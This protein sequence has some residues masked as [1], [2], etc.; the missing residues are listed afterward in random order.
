MKEKIS[1]SALLFFIA[2]QIC[3]SQ[4]YFIPQSLGV[5]V[6]SSY[7][8]INP[9]PTP[10]GKTVY[11]TR[12]D[13][14]ENSG[15]AKKSADILFTTLK[16]DGTWSSAQSVTALNKGKYNTALSFSDNGNQLLFYSD[17][18]FYLST[19]RADTWSTPEKL[20]FKA[21]KD[22]QLSNDGQ[23]LIFSKGGSIFISAKNDDGTW[24]KPATIKSIT[25]KN[26]EA[27]FLLADN[28]TIFFTSK[29]KIRKGDLYKIERTGS[30]WN[31]WSAPVALN[32]TINTNDDE[33]WLR[34][35]NIGSW[36][37]FATTKSAITNADLYRI[38]LFE[39]NPFIEVAGKVI[40]AVSKRPLYNKSITFL[41]NDNPIDSV[42]FDKDSANY[43]VKLPLGKKYDLTAHVDHYKAQP[44][45]IDATNTKEFTAIGTY[46]EEI[47]EPYVLLKG[48]FLIK[49]TD[50]IIPAYAKP[51]IIIDAE[52][53]DSATIDYT[54]GMY[55]IKL[56][57]GALYYVQV[58]ATHFES[59]PE[60]VDFTT[61]DGY[62][63]IT[64]DL[65][66]DAEKMAII[67]GEIIDKETGKPLT[68]PHPVSIKVEGIESLYSS[69]DSLLG[70]YDLRLPLQKIY[71]ISAASPGYYPV[72]ELI[73]VSHDKEEIKINK[74]L[75][76]APVKKGGAVSLK[77][78][79]F[80]PGKTSLT[81]ESNAELDRLADFL[82]ANPAIKIELG[83]YSKKG[84]KISSLNAT[85]AVRT[86]LVSKGVS[87][88]RI[89][90]R[91]YGP[92]KTNS[93][94]GLENQSLKIEFTFVT[95]D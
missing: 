17:N 19:K 72:Y 33:S 20:T 86:Y 6:N 51:S 78:I 58:S 52:N 10:D 34:T 50:N 90:V 27:P 3:F 1:L 45:S 9:V 18:V 56:K 67:T 68:T 55:S 43:I 5:G 13:H 8:E 30:D 77:N 75:M 60:I 83:G 48:K 14:P 22:A 92:V 64:L 24:T 29:S 11:F 66:A 41:A 63:E 82:T 94:D 89:M 39:D 73:D 85:K 4:S 54:S 16:S 69:I 61:F 40:N 26:I 81:S 80:E 36:A 88:S 42:V 53:A 70:T 57:H 21:S 79:F 74:V 38:K 28:K 31:L 44:F 15:G 71:T 2:I 46:L 76:A 23:H 25:L 12:L 49:N 93:W 7:N 91:G 35:N 87:A 62:E 47:P 59:F 84:V 65:Q 95:V 37:F 32:D